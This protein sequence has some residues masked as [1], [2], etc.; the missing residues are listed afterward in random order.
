MPSNSSESPLVLAAR[1]LKPRIAAAGNEIEQSRQLPPEIVD[2]MRS[3]GLFHLTVP[4]E[5]G[6]QQADPLILG[7]VIEEIASADG[8]AG[9]CLM[10]ASQNA[11]FSGFADRTASE[12]IVAN[13]GIMAGVARPI[14]RA[15]PNRDGSF[16]VSGRWPFASGSSHARYFAAECLVYDDNG[17]APRKNEGGDGVS[18]MAFV[19]REQVT[20]HDTWDTI[21]LRGTASHDFSIDAAVV[22]EPFMMK[23]FPAPWHPW[24][25]YRTL[26][27]MFITHGAHSLGVAR[28][29]LETTNSIA[30]EK[31]GYGSDKPIAH[32]SRMQHVTAEAFVT[33]AAGREHMYG[34]AA[35]L[36]DAAERGDDLGKLNA[37]VRLATS[38]A[39][40][41]SLRAVEL[42]YG[43]I[44]TSAIFTRSPLDRQFR[45]MRT[46]AA[47]VMVG[48]LTYEAA[49]RVELG[50]PAGMAFFD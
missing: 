19:P 10:I 4:R 41:S 50:L 40:T 16:T 8:S 46:A 27:L 6:G 9:W 39:A 49:G 21:G 1:E 45:D 25:F 26:A 43:S 37:R 38:Y 30:R 14:G 3:A 18:Y 33:V 47:H 32:Q 42:L 34:A 29:A 15:V 44:A 17:N 12:A 13:G 24:T 2:A 11:A 28:A 7:T 48:P 5:L 36:W 23:M 35:R 31:I 20:I 22:S